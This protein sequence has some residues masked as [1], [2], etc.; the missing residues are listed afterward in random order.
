MVRVGRDVG[1]R[2]LLIG[3]MGV[4]SLQA[5]GRERGSSLR[6]MQPQF[7]ALPDR[8]LPG[9][10]CS[11]CTSY[12]VVYTVCTPTTTLLIPLMRALFET[13]RLWRCP[14][15]SGLTLTRTVAPGR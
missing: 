8:Y 2:N 3:E 14:H 1:R 6:H 10:L 9:V 7:Q 12:E 11:V 15:P 5:W 13:M 4:N